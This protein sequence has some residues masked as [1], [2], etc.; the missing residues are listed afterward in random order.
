MG[1]V[2]HIRSKRAAEITQISC[3]PAN[4]VQPLQYFLEWNALLKQPSGKAVWDSHPK[5]NKAGSASFQA[6]ARRDSSVELQRWQSAW[7]LTAHPGKEK[8]LRERK[9]NSPKINVS[10]SRAPLCGLGATSSCLGFKGSWGHLGLR[11][12]SSPLS[13]TSPIVLAASHRT[14]NGVLALD[15][16]EPAASA[17]QI[18]L[19]T[20]LWSHLQARAGAS[21]HQYLSRLTSLLSGFPVGCLQSFYWVSTV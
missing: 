15:K 17:L 10:P 4:K 8:T 13:P 2:R 3:G 6:R 11:K 16:R 18:A 21:L 14:R 1:K 19:C 12:P 9:Q 5:N 7:G 20:W